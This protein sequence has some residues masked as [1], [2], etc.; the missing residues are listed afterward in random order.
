[1][2]ATPGWESNPEAEQFVYG[3]SF[4]KFHNVR[5]AQYCRRLRMVSDLFKQKEAPQQALRSKLKAIRAPA[6]PPTQETNGSGGGAASRNADLIT[7]EGDGL[8][9]LGWT[10]LTFWKITVTELETHIESVDGDL[11]GQI[12]QR[13]RDL[14]H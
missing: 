12:R 3:F 5:V 8:V 9:A 7:R 4:Q 10:G 6:K 1:M 11:K 13:K 2:E 14:Q